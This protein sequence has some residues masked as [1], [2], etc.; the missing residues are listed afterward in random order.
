MS[1][2]SDVRIVTSKKGYKEL[3]KYVKDN[4]PKDSRDY[5]L[6]NSK[7]VDMWNEDQMYF[8][9]NAIKW[10]EYSDFKEVDTIMN[11]LNHLRD[12]E[13]SYCYARIGENTDDY[14]EKYFTGDLDGILHFPQVE[15]YFDDDQFDAIY[16][17][18]G[19]DVEM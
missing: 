1:Y 3:E 19:K 6:L 9:W 8:G 17:N 11:G 5:N 14:D 4:L 7:D 12:C 13:Y 15:R 10:Y 18:V 2:R 16:E